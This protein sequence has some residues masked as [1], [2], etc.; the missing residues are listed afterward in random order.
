MW[1]GS[2]PRTENSRILSL[3][4][5]DGSWA[6]RVRRTILYHSLPRFET[7][8][9]D[10]AMAISAE[11]DQIFICV[12][13]QPASRVDVVDLK[14]MGSPAVLA[15]PAVTFQHC[16]AEFAVRIWLQPKSRSLR[17]EISH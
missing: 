16:D 11:G 8:S 9:V 4:P 3:Q 5:E 17:L 12:V 7:I 15:S 6:G 10:V 14:T 2:E 13:T 1:E